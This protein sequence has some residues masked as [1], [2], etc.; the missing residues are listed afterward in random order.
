MFPCHFWRGENVSSLFILSCFLTTGCSI[1][2]SEEWVQSNKWLCHE[3]GWKGWVRNSPSRFW[4]RWGHIVGHLHGHA[5]YPPMSPLKNLKKS[6]MEER[7]HSSSHQKL[8]FIPGPVNVTEQSGFY[9]Q[10][11]CNNNNNQIPFKVV[12]LK[13]PNVCILAE[14]VLELG[15]CLIALPPRFQYP[16]SIFSGWPWSFRVPPLFSQFRSKPRLASV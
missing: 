7:S 11:P 4:G 8:Y 16:E 2:S 13:R 9:I 10:A 1:S 6:I 14:L 12:D 15:R 3:Q 5:D